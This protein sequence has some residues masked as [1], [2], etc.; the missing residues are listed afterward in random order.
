LAK[1]LVKKAV[2]R[3]SNLEELRSLLADSI[4]LAES[5]RAFLTGGTRAGDTPAA[6][7]ASPPVRTEALVTAGGTPLPT[8]DAAAL[9]EIE[10]CLAAA[11]GPVARVLVKRFARQT[12]DLNL[13]CRQLADEISSAD[14]RKGFLLAVDKHLQ[15]H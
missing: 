1:I 3:A 8:T 9:D 4:P 5:R 11:L 12:G 15:H 2:K 13:L 7:D 6:P 10:R 14:Q